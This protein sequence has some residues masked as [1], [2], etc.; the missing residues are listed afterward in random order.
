MHCFMF[1]EDI[2]RKRDK[3]MKRMCIL[4]AITLIVSVV[5]III[6]IVQITESGGKFPYNAGGAIIGGI[7]V[8]IAL[9]SDNRML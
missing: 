5:S 9:L 2:S 4:N 7:M 8:C 6:G 3:L 1:I